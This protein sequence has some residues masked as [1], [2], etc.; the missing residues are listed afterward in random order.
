MSISR[1]ILFSLLILQTISLDENTIYSQDVA[2][3]NQPNYSGQV[4]TK[5]C[6]SITPSLAS[7][8]SFE[9]QCC[10]VTY[11]NDALLS[12]KKVFGENWKETLCQMYGLDTDLSESEIINILS[13]GYEQNICTHFTY[14]GMNI[15][16]YSLSLSAVDGD[17]SYNCGDGEQKFNSKTFVPSNENEKISKDMADCGYEFTEKNCYK[18]ANKLITDDIQCCWCETTNLSDAAYGYSNQLCNG[19]S[20]NGLDNILQTTVEL[21]KNAGIKTKM[22]CSCLDKNGIT[23]NVSTNTVTGEVIVN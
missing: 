16:L 2:K 11:T 13:L 4:T 21:Q 23:T 5:N 17:V 9:G 6:I 22:I 7:T 18:R 12:Y 20:T 19:Y 15:A 14:T 10:R 1:I 3:C 8:G